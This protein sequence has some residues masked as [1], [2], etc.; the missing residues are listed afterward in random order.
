MSSTKEDIA[1][2]ENRLHE[3][4]RKA[5]S[6]TDA[7]VSVFE[8]VAH[9]LRRGE[10]ETSELVTPIEFRRTAKPIVIGLIRELE[11]FVT[12]LNQRPA[13]KSDTTVEISLQ[14]AAS[15]TRLTEL[16]SPE[17]LI[18]ENPVWHDQVQVQ[19]SKTLSAL[20]ELK[21]NRHLNPRE[22]I[23]AVQDAAIRIERLVCLHE[24]LRMRSMVSD[25]KSETKALSDFLR[26]GRTD[27]GLLV[28]VD[29][30]DVLD[31]ACERILPAARDRDIEIRRRYSYN[32]YL[33]K[34]DSKQ[35]LTAI[36][37]LL[38]NAI[39]YSQPIRLDEPKASWVSLRIAGD[40]SFARIEVENWGVPIKAEEIETGRIFERG[41]RG[42]LPRLLKIAGSGT[43]LA[44]VR[45]IMSDLGGAVTCKSHPARP[46][47]ARK[48]YRKRFLTTF[49]LSLPR[50]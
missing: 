23:L 16:I 33:C 50:T 1:G 26:S 24:L 4:L 20:T 13:E 38:D 6:T 47:Y 43:G 35:L 46:E 10:L 44:V 48:D 3:W 29:L 40:D 42:E 39:K 22:P 49:A 32:T 15:A 45:D 31:T 37:N 2:S 30:A 25:L 19:A 9:H 17:N 34:T 41:V 28:E 14:L 21:A 7:I 11:S 27:V 36:G 8:S 12:K 18:G 5:N